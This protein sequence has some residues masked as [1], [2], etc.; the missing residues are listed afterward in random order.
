[1]FKKDVVNTQAL[2]RCSLRETHS[3]F[4]EGV[5]SLFTLS[6]MIARLA[7]LRIS[8]DEECLTIFTK[9]VLSVMGSR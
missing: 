4:S 8:G 7:T 3:D 9:V 2:W 5:S 6:S 1:M